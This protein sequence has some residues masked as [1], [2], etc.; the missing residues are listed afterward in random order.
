MAT[1]I[2][3]DDMWAYVSCGELI[4]VVD[5]YSEDVAMSNIDAIVDAW[6][7]VGYVFY[8]DIAETRMDEDCQGA[9]WGILSI[10]LQGSFGLYMGREEQ[11]R[12]YLEDIF[13]TIY[14]RFGGWSEWQ[15]YIERQKD[16]E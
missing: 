2:N 5:G 14:S 13:D 6:D 7:C 8:S 1:H 10:T 11:V 9:T 3:T 16:H 12:K 15:Q 4:A